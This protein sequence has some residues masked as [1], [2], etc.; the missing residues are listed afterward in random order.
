MKLVVHI[1]KMPE[2]RYPRKCYEML[3]HIDKS[4]VR[5]KPTWIHHVKNLLYLCNL[6]D[7][8]EQQE[9][10]DENIFICTFVENFK[11]YLHDNWYSEI[12]SLGKLS[13]YREFKSSLTTEKYLSVVKI[14]V[15]M[16]MFARLRC[17]SHYLRIETDRKL[18]NDANEYE[19]VCYVIETMGSGK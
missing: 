16:F 14:N 4:G 8:W 10:P 1:L 9:V 18:K 5:S 2:N 3:Y 6:Q 15:H 13:C 19:Y 7:V 11:R 17:S 12:C